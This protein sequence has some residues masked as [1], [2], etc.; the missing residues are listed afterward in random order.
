MQAMAEVAAERE[1][2][3]V[4]GF[5]VLHTDGHEERHQTDECECPPPPHS[6]TV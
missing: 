3:I 5:D 6:P 2:G 1:T 4:D